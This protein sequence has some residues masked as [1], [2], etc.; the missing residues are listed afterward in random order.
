LRGGGEKGKPEKAEKVLGRENSRP[1]AKSISFK[2]SVENKGDEKQLVKKSRQKKRRKRK[3][4]DNDVLPGK[5]K[6]DKKKETEKRRVFWGEKKEREDNGSRRSR[7]ILHHPM[8]KF[9][10]A[11]MTAGI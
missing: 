11:I 4:P 8:C 10:H 6:V 2:G 9:L 7:K 1:L 5:K 3:D